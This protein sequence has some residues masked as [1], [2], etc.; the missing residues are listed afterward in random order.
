MTRHKPEKFHRVIMLRVS[1]EQEKMVDELV[2]SYEVTRSFVI[3]YG[4][5]RTW[6]EN[7]IK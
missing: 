6:E 3:R 5:E 7:R 1:P 4:I 2:K